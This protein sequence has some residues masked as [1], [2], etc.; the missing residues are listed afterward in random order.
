MLAVSTTGLNIVGNC[1]Y[2]CDYIFRDSLGEADAIPTNIRAYADKAHPKTAVLLYPNDDKFSSDGAQVVQ[3]SVA[4]SNIRLLETIQFT[5]GEA[6]L[7]PYVTRAVSQHPDVIFITSLG[8]IPSKIMIEARREG[9]T[10]QFL[11]GNGFNTA[12]VSKAAGDAGK[13]AQSASAWYLGNTFKTNAEFVKAYKD[14][15]G[16][17]PDQFAAQAYTGVLILADAAKRANLSLTNVAADRTK[18]KAA[19]EKT[20]IDTPLGPFQFTPTHDVHQTIWVIAMDGAG[21]FNL[22]TS[23]KPT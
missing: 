9:F 10:G 6:D 23:I 19:L 2:P 22:V 18:L 8:D 14:R 20:N 16:T 3:N 5:K 11:G 1:P 7:S 12:A 13:G 21:G 15:F 17:D 4:A